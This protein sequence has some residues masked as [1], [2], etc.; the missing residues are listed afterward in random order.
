MKKS[1]LLLLILCLMVSS[2]SVAL[3]EVK[4][5]PKVL[6][7]FFSRPDGYDGKWKWGSDPLTSYITE[8]TGIS[9]DITYA[10]T[11]DHQE[12]YT[13]LASD[14][15]DYDLLYLGKYEP[16]LIDEGYVLPFNKL[17]DQYYPE[18]WN[19]LPYQYDKVHTL[20]DGNIYYYAQQYADAKR[21]A[22]L[23]GKSGIKGWTSFTHNRIL[24]EALGNPP[25][26]TLAEVKAAAIMAKEQGSKYPVFLTLND[27]VY[28]NLNPLQIINC[29]FAGPSFVYPQENG[30][31]T[32]NV[33]SEEY[34]KAAYWV[35]SLYREGLISADN[36]TFTWES[37]D[38]NVRE[39]AQ[40][41]D[42]LIILGQDGIMNQH[43][44]GFAE[45]PMYIQTA[46]ALADGVKREEIIMDDAGG[47]KIGTPAW[48]ILDKT[49]QPEEC[50]KFISMMWR[51]DIDAI[52]S[53]G[54]EG[55]HYTFD[56]TNAEHGVPI[57][58]PE[59]VTDLK[60]L[61]AAEF[62]NKWGYGNPIVSSFLTRYS[63]QYTNRPH[64][65]VEEDGKEVHY[66]DMCIELFPEYST[67]FKTGYLTLNFTS[68]DDVLLLNNVLNAWMQSIPDMVLA[69]DDTS[70]EQA[71]E[72]C[73]SNMEVVGL[74]ELETKMTERYTFYYKELHE[75]R[76]A[77]WDWV[78]D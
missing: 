57:S 31:V 10:T 4:E 36:F 33:K 7:V 55:I 28:G 70:F 48:Y 38:E 76:N 2:A 6:T 60:T 8:Q 51:E 45:F 11:S 23:P 24:R 22:S 72:N 71:Y 17:A 13:M 39:I 37:T 5:E 74:S 66:G 67:P 73:I 46:P 54:I 27:A 78:L 12:F 69:P 77:K 20:A 40:S 58:T 52:K 44:A 25:L 53:D 68:S 42:P 16:A 62:Q 64:I 56:Y 9:L 32:F 3:C 50:I 15:L 14:T 65:V 29:C 35:N 75:I 61:P 1:L 43:I 26:D 41:G 34:K 49:D 30:V 19:L 47:S 21:L 18:F 59:M 63:I